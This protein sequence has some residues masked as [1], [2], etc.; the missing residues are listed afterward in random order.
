MKVSGSDN[1][2][3]NLENDDLLFHYTRTSTALEKI[4]H[5]GKI[6][7]RLL[8]ETND[9]REYKDKILGAFGWSLRP[10]DNQQINAADKALRRILEKECRAMSFCANSKP[11]IV[12]NSGVRKEDGTANTVGWNK[13]RM[14]SQY[15]E[16][17]HG[18]CL[19]FSK[20]AL[21]AEINTKKEIIKFFRDQHVMYEL[22][23]RPSIKSSTIDATRLRN[24][25]VEVYCMNHIRDNAEAL[26]FTKDIDYRDENEYRFIL[27]D[28]DG[29]IE[30]IEIARSIKCLIQGDRTAGVYSPL[31][32]ELCI[33]Y[34][35]E[36]RKVLWDGGQAHLRSL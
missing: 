23:G 22:P 31:I 15:G 17:H 7:L 14:W 24:E 10:E 18:I 1:L 30:Y 21:K 26:F 8:T 12:F 32:Q 4:L 6:R 36:Q 5:E 29:K 25:G 35:I 33:R 20:N 3:P 11:T 19:A 34:R 2:G 16:D 9:P 13:P 27:F 28:P